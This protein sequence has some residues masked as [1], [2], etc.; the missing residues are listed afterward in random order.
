MVLFLY[1]KK[2]KKIQNIVVLEAGLL[3]I[4]KNWMMMDE[5]GKKKKKKIA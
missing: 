3:F 5:G 2:F 4:L 1:I